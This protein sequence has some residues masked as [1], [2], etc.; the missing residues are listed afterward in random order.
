MP[1]PKHAPCVSRWARRQSWSRSCLGCGGFIMHGLS[2]PVMAVVEAKD[3]NLRNGLGQCIAQ[4]TRPCC[5][6]SVLVALLPRSV[7]L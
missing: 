3:D 4:H 5:T 6:C 1:T 7:A 2:A